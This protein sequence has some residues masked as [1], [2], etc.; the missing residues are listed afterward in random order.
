MAHG[1]TLFGELQRLIPGHVFEKLE[2]KHKTGRA[3]RKFG[4]KA[5]FAV[6]SFFMLSACNTMREGI[7]NLHPI[8]GR[9]YHWGIKQVTRSPFSDAISK[10]SCAFFED[11]FSETYKVCSSYAPKKP[12]KFKCK[13]YSFDSTTISLCL[14]LFPWATFRRRKGGI[15]MHTLLD[16]DGCLPAFVEISEAKTHDSKMAQA[17][18]LP[19]GSIVAC[20]RG[21]VSFP[22]FYSPCE[23]G[24]FFVTRL[25]KNMKFKLRERNTNKW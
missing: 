2:R 16:H 8:P 6:I 12:F 13:P 9:L 3:S 24:V 15:K 25:K 5:Q 14:S 23:Q 18:K 1:T 4:F 19:K 7:R 17:L 22:W 10:R 21:Y 11:L 20:D